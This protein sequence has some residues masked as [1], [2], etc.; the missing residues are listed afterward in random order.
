MTYYSYKTN[1]L[2]VELSNGVYKQNNFN[3]DA[4]E[5]AD[6]IKQ[7]YSLANGNNTTY[8]SFFKNN[9]INNIFF[10]EISSY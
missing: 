6:R 3:I 8:F 5:A 10:I 2:L 9:I 7:Y 4:N 1:N